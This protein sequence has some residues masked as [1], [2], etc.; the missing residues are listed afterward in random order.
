MKKN[1]NFTVANLKYFDKVRI[2]FLG[3]GTSQGVPV[4]SCQCNIC[5]SKEKKDKR[6]R[7]SVMIETEDTNLVIDAGP[8]F[9]YQMLREDVRRLDAILLTHAHKDHIGGLDDIR[10][11]NYTQKQYMDVY[12]QTAV[13]SVIKKEYHYAFAD[14]RYP[15]VPD[16]NLHNLQ[17]KAFVINNTEILPIEVL[18]HKLPVFGYRIKNFA[19]ISDAN[20]IAP[21]EKE[22]IKDLDLLVIN[23]LRQQK[24]IS[25]FTLAE[26]LEL[27]E[28]LKPK[29]AFLT[30]ISHQ[31]GLHSEINNILPSNVKLAYD[32]LE[33]TV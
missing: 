28:E 18:H 7:A 3:T 20:Y 30:H 26:A 21:E 4:I 22:K 25:H 2:K 32:R 6:L 16:M 14:N 10:A 29:R 27:I 13:N 12:A 8:D 15:G 24:H 19:Y 1:N 31:M 9:R 17:N 23:A 5:L 11:F 33:L